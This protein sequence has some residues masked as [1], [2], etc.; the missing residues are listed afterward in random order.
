MAPQSECQHLNFRCDA[1]IGRLSAVEGG[2]VTGYCAYV[3]VKCIDCGVPF[4]W[5]GIAAGNHYAEPR[6]SIDGIEL[7]A[8]LEPATHERFAPVASYTMP[9]RK[10]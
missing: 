3:R 9:P 6:V 8:P 4:R 7:R 10:H 2:P 1:S 5:V